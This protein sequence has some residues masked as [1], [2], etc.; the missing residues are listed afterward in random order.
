[1][2]NDPLQSQQD[3]SAEAATSHPANG[4]ASIAKPE[5]TPS[6][7][8]LYQQHHHSLSPATI[9]PFRVTLS[10]GHEP[11]HGAAPP[12][13]I[14]RQPTPISTAAPLPFSA[15]QQLHH[16]FSSPS[17]GP[18]SSPSSSS[19][20][21]VAHSVTPDVGHHSHAYPHSIPSNPCFPPMAS[22]VPA[23]SPPGYTEEKGGELGSRLDVDLGM[24]FELDPLMATTDQ[25]QAPSE[26]PSLVKKAG[27]SQKP[28]RPPNAWILYRSDKLRAIAAGEP[29]PGLD[30]IIAETTVS[31]SSGSANSG[32][33]S[34]NLGKG[35]GG[36][37]EETPASS[38]GSDGQVSSKGSMLPPPP[39]TNVKKPK[40]GSKEPTEGFLSLGRG[41]A[42]R[43]LPQA[44]VSKMISMLW[45]RESAQVRGGYEKMA[46]L[47]KVEVSRTIHSLSTL[48]SH[49]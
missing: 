21:S 48:H 7:D 15:R 27:R 3:T 13:N 30:A 11:S 29:V 10:A 32:E 41:K 5:P 14:P 28:P 26:T 20:E 33:D 37:K 9:L 17:V 22:T 12:Q 2:S 19:A 1:M 4:P 42:G 44:D 24:E 25:E 49:T 38:A 45:K 8:R 47:K 23:Q 6:S 31:S 39:P 43:G 36:S 40:K 34:L 35:K 46:Q 18:I 16:A